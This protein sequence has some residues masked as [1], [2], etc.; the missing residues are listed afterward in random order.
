MVNGVNGPECCQQKCQEVKES[1][2]GFWS[3][4]SNTRICYRLTGTPTKGDCEE[5]TC[6]R[7]PRLC[8]GNYI[9]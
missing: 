7:G 6:T 2:C 5:S 4:D 1:E 3:Y 8:D 9:T